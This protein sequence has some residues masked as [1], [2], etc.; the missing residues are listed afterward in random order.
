M[1]CFFFVAERLI[2]LALPDDAKKQSSNL[3]LSASFA[4]L[5][6]AIHPLRVEAVAMATDRK[7]LLATIFV[8]GLSG[9]TCRA[10]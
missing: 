4:T 1:Q 7:E 5:L 2:A 6:F 10:G 3:V 8:S 9:F